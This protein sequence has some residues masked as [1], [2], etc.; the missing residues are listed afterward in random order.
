MTPLKPSPR[1]APQAP[2]RHV[3]PFPRI[4]IPEEARELPPSTA[5]PRLEQAQ[6]QA[7]EQEQGRGKRRKVAKKLFDNST[8]R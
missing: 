5:P 2:I 7:E 8:P 6:W 3:A 4:D 1:R